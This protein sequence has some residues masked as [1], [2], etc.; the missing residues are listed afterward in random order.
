MKRLWVCLIGLLSLSGCQNAPPAKTPEGPKTLAVTRWTEKSELFMEYPAL[1]SR[2]KA[3]FAVHFTELRN[4]KPA[5]AGPVVVELRP[6]NGPVQSFSADAPSRPGIFGLDVQ[7]GGPGTYSLTVRLD[8]TSL[9]DTHELGEVTV[10]ADLRQ[11]EAASP[12][13]K[14]EGKIGRAHV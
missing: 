2:E 13:A 8:S 12:T 9:K 14:G 7:P 4:F 10:F 5:G 1:V 3:R 11:A 6:A